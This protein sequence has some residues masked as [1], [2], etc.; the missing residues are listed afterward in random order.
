VN[1]P[2]PRD[3]FH[4]ASNV[5]NAPAVSSPR[6][7]KRRAT[8][9]RPGSGRYITAGK[10]ATL[11]LWTPSA[12][13][14]VTYFSDAYF[15]LLDRH[16]G[17]G[18]YSHAP[19]VVRGGSAARYCE[20]RVTPHRMADD[21]HAMNRLYAFE[22]TLSVSPGSA[23]DDSVSDWFAENHQALITSGALVFN[24]DGIYTG[25]GNRDIELRVHNLD[26][27]GRFHFFSLF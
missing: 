9:S 26:A 18:R 21:G 16:P 23:V 7:P 17:I 8:H 27:A 10:L 3:A 24:F 22:S 4:T 19:S 1:G 20:R 13:V 14:D 25:N 11:P 12:I 15:A 5:K 6:G 2:K